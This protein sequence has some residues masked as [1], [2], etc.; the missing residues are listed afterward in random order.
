VHHGVVVV[1]L[2][3]SRGTDLAAALAASLPAAAPADDD[4]AAA[5]P[6][7]GERTA[8]VAG[9]VG[10]VEGK[11]SNAVRQLLDGVRDLTRQLSVYGEQTWLAMVGQLTALASEVR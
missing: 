3:T 4:A 2:S 11:T 10:Y 8:W 6:S 7:W 9:A 1:L 5:A